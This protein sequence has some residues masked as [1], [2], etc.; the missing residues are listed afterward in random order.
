MK[1][2]IGLVGGM[3][4]GKDTWGDFLATEHGGVHASTSDVARGYI[5]ENGLGVPTRDRVREVATYLRSTD[6]PTILVER[7]LETAGNAELRIIT[8]LYVPGELQYIKDLGG[9]VVGVR[10]ADT[11]RLAR[12]TYRQ[13]A[14]EEAGSAEEF[15]RMDDNDMHGL[16]NTDQSLAEVFREVDMEI[17]GDIPI[18]DI[19][20]CRQIADRIIKRSQV[21]V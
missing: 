3:C 1:S 15:R 20:R 16:A 12:M 8:G 10:T 6:G 17:D 5:K 13:R 7:A 4:S 2:I 19:E 14:G 21:S 11:V 18:A 9:F